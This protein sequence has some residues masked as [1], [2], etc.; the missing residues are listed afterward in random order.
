MMGDGSMYYIPII[1]FIILYLIGFIP[2]LIIG[3]IDITEKY[4]NKT[5]SMYINVFLKCL[6]W[7][8]F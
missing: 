3:I 5:I 6:F 2:L 1:L 7:P 4:E 8:F